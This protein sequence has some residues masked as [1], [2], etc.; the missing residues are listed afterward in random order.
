MKQEFNQQVKTALV[1]GASGNLGKAIA[2]QLL[3]DGYQVIGT[4]SSGNNKAA[5]ENSHYRQEALD[6]RSPTEASAFLD[7]LIAEWGVPEL[8]VLTVGGFAM[9]RF[10]EM[11]FADLSAQIELNVATAF[12]IA[13]PLFRQMMQVGKGKIFFIGA[14]PGLDARFSGGA[15]AY[16]LSKS[17]LFRL[18]AQMNE[19]ARGSNVVTA[20]IVPGIIDTPQNRAAMP[21]ANPKGWVQPAAIADLVSFYASPAADSLREPILKIYNQS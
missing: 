15:V 10:S 17:L 2:T 16:G 14:K 5:L 9:G 6:L 1:T 8:A 18:A 11:T 12:N 7:N 19:E 13:Q 21:D 4:V 20:V 3:A